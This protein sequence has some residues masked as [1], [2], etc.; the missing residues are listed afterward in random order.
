VALDPHV[1]LERLA[2]EVR[3][4]RSG[5]LPAEGLHHQVRVDAAH[6]RRCYLALRSRARHAEVD[7]FRGEMRLA[8]GAGARRF[9]EEIGALLLQVATH[10]AGERLDDAEP[11]QRWRV[12]LVTAS[13]SLSV[14]LEEGVVGL[15]PRAVRTADP[16]ARGT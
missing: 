3:K 4:R 7:A 9:L 6:A 11:G 14:A 12:S 15:G 13:R 8:T 5:S 2:G 16:V 10:L 1:D